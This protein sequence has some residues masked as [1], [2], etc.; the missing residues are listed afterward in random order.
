MSTPADV[1][2]PASTTSPR[3]VWSRLLGLLGGRTR[4][5]EPLDLELT[6]AEVDADLRHGRDEA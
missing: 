5:T 2:P 1:P 3:G 4:G 6:Q